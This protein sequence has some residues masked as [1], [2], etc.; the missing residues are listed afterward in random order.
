[1]EQFAAA[2]FPEGVQAVYEPEWRFTLYPEA[3]GPL[4]GSGPSLAHVLTDD[5]FVSVVLHTELTPAFP[6]VGPILRFSPFAVW[7]VSIG[8]YGIWYFGTF[9]V[10]PLD[11][12]DTA[13][14]RE[15]KKESK[16]QGGL[17]GGVGLQAFADTRIKFKAGPVLGIAQLTVVRNDLTNYAGDLEWYWD[18]TDQINSPA[19]GWVVRRTGYLFWDIVHPTTATAKRLWIGSL[20]NW[21]SCAI[22][23]DRNIRLGPIVLWK[24]LDAA[25]MPTIALGSQAWLVSRFHDTWP[26]YT[27]LALRWES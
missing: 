21:T 10:F 13:A 4:S 3:E 12:P 9:A 6:R 5:N 26:P 15:W 19:H 16:S 20:L 22:T 25:T 7:D 27:F 1:M 18:P 8:A 2:G 23:D 14:T 24:P 11:D 17:E